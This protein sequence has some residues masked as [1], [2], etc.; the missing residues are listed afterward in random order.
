MT[1]AFSRAGH[2]PDELITTAKSEHRPVA[3][4]C[5]FSD[6][7]AEGNRAGEVSRKRPGLLCEPCEARQRNP[8]PPTRQAR[9]RSCCTRRR[10]PRDRSSRG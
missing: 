7:D 10:K 5:L 6:Y 8:V 9:R 4:W 1:L 3:T 2:A